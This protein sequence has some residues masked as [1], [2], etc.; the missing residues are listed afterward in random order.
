MD[1][2]FEKTTNPYATASCF[3]GCNINQPPCFPRTVLHD[4]PARH[5]SMHAS[6]SDFTKIYS[7]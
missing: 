4:N 1:I 2:F 7:T 5:R 6:P 3:K